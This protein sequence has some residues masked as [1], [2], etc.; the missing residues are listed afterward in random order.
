MGHLVFWLIHI[1]LIGLSAFVFLILTIPLHILYASSRSKQFQQ[2]KLGEQMNVQNELLEKQNKIAQG[3]SK[4]ELKAE[5][6]AAVEKKR[7]EDE[8]LKR[9]RQ[10]VFGFIFISIIALMIFDFYF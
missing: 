9:E 5:E 6:E 2:N 4:E 7:K 3:M 1:V 10:R 8:R